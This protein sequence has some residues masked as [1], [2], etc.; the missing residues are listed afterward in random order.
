M[1]VYQ[2]KDEPGMPIFIDIGVEYPSG[3]GVTLLVWADHYDQFAEMINDVDDGGAW[4]S[5]TGYMGVYNGRPQFDS[6]EGYLE[7]RWWTGVR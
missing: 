7:Y 2:A 5:V 4:L 3:N 1:N 6:G